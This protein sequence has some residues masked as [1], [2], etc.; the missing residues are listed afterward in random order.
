MLYIFEIFLWGGLP[1]FGLPMCN[2]QKGIILFPT[3]DDLLTNDGTDTFDEC[4]M[5]VVV[6]PFNYSALTLSKCI[7]TTIKC[8][9]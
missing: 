6:F 9:V 5:G 8:R 4:R 1:L 7:S 2:E 3:C